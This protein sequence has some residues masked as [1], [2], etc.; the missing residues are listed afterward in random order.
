LYLKNITNYDIMNALFFLG[1]ILVIGLLIYRSDNVKGSMIGG[2]SPSRNSLTDNN[3][4]E[5]VY[6][7]MDLKNCVQ[8]FFCCD[9][10]AIVKTQSYIPPQNKADTCAYAFTSPSSASSTNGAGAFSALSGLYNLKVN[11]NAAAFTD[12]EIFDNAETDLV[13]TPCGPLSTFNAYASPL[14]VTR[15]S[16]FPNSL[17]MGIDSVAGPQVI[18]NTMDNAIPPHMMT[19]VELVRRAPYGI[20]EPQ[21]LPVN[22]LPIESPCNFESEFT[23]LA[24][25][26]KRNTNI[27]FKDEQ[28]FPICQTAWPDKMDCLNNI[29]Y[30]TNLSPKENFVVNKI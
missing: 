20:P 18:T 17:T 1:L 22:A 25:F 10:S 19:Q 27:F 14:A 15:G 24:S 28:Q 12:K 7:E 13:K 30:S 3:T 11:A 23:N 9:D 29:M 5:Y 4:S 6:K 16:S 2:G 21:P 26:F 8:P